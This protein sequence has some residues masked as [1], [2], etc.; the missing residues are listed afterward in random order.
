VRRA[1]VL[2]EGELRRLQRRALAA[3]RRDQGEVCGI[4]FVSPA[5]R[6]SLHFLANRSDVRGSFEI[7]KAD[8]RAARLKSENPKVSFAGIFH[9][10]PVGP[11]M[12]GPRDIRETPANWLHLVYDVCGTAPR[13]WVIRSRS[14]KKS[15]VPIELRIRRK[16]TR[17]RLRAG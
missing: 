8:L 5:R 10:H 14:Q 2:E 12:L 16:R 7:A 13:L 17:S 9:S 3:Q 15:A 1:Y 6:I 4:L 11:A